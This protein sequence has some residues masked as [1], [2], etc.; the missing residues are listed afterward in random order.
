MRLTSIFLLGSLFLVAC[1]PPS[2]SETATDEPAPTTTQRTAEPSPPTA[3]P[4]ATAWPTEPDPI[5]IEIPTAAPGPTADDTITWLSTSPDGR[6]IAEGQYKPGNSH[7]HIQLIVRKADSSVEWVVVDRT[8]EKAVDQALPEVLQWSQ[9]GQYLYFTNST[10]GDG[11]PLFTANHDLHRVDLNDGHV[12][13]ILPF[14]AWAIAFSPSENTLAYLTNEQ[15]RLIGGRLVLRD[16][17]SGVER[18]IK[19]P[20]NAMTWGLTWSPNG[21]QLAFTMTTDTTACE[22]QGIS[23]IKLDIVTLTQTVLVQDDKRLSRI[24]RWP[25]I[26]R[27]ML[28][29]EEGKL[30]W[31]DVET[32]SVTPAP[33]TL[34]PQPY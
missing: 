9:D 1:M 22:P 26:G 13:E 20:E 21:D 31:L 18:Q 17:A 8:D 34:I 28:M 2:A 3:R 33:E 27:M 11:C 24:V 32:G 23:V 5:H 25:E 30:L 29:D 19:L 4:R 15:G 6:W 14:I 16:L 12:V 7:A 10:L